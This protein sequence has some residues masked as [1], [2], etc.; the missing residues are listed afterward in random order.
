MIYNK[1]VLWDFIRDC[2]KNVLFVF[3]VLLSASFVLIFSVNWSLTSYHELQSSKIDM[4]SY[5]YISYVDVRN[6]IPEIVANYPSNFP[7]YISVTYQNIE[8][9]TL[10]TFNYYGEL[11]KSEKRQLDEY[12][13]SDFE[14]YD[15]SVASNYRKILYV[16]MAVSIIT[17]FIVLIVQFESMKN[18]YKLMRYEL[19]IFYLLGATPNKIKTIIL[20]RTFYVVFSALIISIVVNCFSGRVSVNACVVA[21]I[22]D[23]LAVLINVRK[24][25][26]E[27]REYLHEILY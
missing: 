18:M 9:D 16:T 13:K 15:D 6:K 1:I 27:W 19:S 4:V 21:L 24:F 12:L 5:D 2:K 20:I 14:V 3:C 7:E 17:V 25:F 8:D 26:D 22:V 23:L 10:I 11:S